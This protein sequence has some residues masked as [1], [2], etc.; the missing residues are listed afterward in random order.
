MDDM[1]L[2]LTQKSGFRISQIVSIEC[3]SLFSGG[4]KSVCRLV[5]ILPR[6]LSVRKACHNSSVF[7]YAYVITIPVMLSYKMNI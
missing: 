3:Q 5:K 7:E 6:V 4:E 1:L 2:I